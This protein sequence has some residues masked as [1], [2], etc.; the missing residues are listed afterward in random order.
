MCAWK[1][2]NVKLSL[3]YWTYCSG[4]W[5]CHLKKHKYHAILP[6]N[7]DQ[8]W[9]N[10]LYG[11][12]HFQKMLQPRVAHSY[13]VGK[14]IQCANNHI[15]ILQT[16][17]VFTFGTFNA[18]YTVIVRTETN[19][20]HKILSFYENGKCFTKFYIAYVPRSFCKFRRAA[21]NGLTGR[22]RSSGRSLPTP[23]LGTQ[24]D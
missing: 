16:I 10:V 17:F 19:N 2:C 23:D 20:F 21:W 5:V 8:G 4:W 15:F 7:L 1:H 14:F 13:K 24:V 18:I 9:V 6:D 3:Y 12:P 11:G 22:M